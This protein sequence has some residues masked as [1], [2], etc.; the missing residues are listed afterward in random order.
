VDLD[1]LRVL[2]DGDAEFARELMNSFIEGATSAVRE[3]EQALGRA[4]AR[5]VM[6]HAHTL[7]G[8]GATMQA[9]GVSLAAGR[10][11]AAARSGGQESLAPFVTELHQEVTRAIEY[12]RLKQA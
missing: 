4:D 7:K 12:L 6:G 9:A 3:I 8:S 5:S 11:E 10:L 2:A 1:A